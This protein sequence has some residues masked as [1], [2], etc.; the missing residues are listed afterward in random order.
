[1]LAW[2]KS[3][4]KCADTQWGG[5]GFSLKELSCQPSLYIVS[6]ERSVFECVYCYYTKCKKKED[7]VVVH[8]CMLSQLHKSACAPKYMVQVCVFVCVTY[9]TDI[10]GIEQVKGQSG[11][12]IH[13]QPGRDIV[14]A[15][16]AG[17]VHNLTGGAHV[18][19]PEVQHDIC[20]HTTHS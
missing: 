14:D 3:Q 9:H 6:S 1:M 8:I 20:H 13:K 15:N 5:V 10:E 17:V 7:T 2:K 16:G 4:T 12:Q 19:G 18:G 11:D